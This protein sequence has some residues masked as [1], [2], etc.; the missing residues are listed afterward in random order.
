[1]GLGLLIAF[2]IPQTG[3]LATATWGQVCLS[4]KNAR[5]LVFLSMAFW[6][7]VALAMISNFLFIFL[8]G[9]GADEVSLG[10]T[11]TIAT[12]SELSILFLSDRLLRAGSAAGAFL[13]GLLYEYGVQ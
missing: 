1:M 6:S 9:L 3:Y 12:F 11:M 4:L 2:S 10:L 13:G 5:W 7:G 8:R